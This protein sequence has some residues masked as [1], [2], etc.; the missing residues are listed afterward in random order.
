[1]LIHPLLRCMRPRKQRAKPGGMVM[2]TEPDGSKDASVDTKGRYMTGKERRDAIVKALHDAGAPVSGRALAQ[3]VGVSRQ[4]VVQDM[5]LL[6]ADGHDIVAT[7]RGY[8]LRES[9]RPSVPTRL[10]KVRHTVEE[11]GDELNT[12]VD[13]GGAALN[14][15]V[16]HRVYG[17]ITADLDVRSRR[18]VERYLEGI[19]SGKSF[20]LM[21]VTSGYHFHRIAAESE[22]ILEEIEEALAAKGY[23]AEV[24]PYERDVVQA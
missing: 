15:M 19:R 11:V 24:L 10:I 3:A 23:L 21:T 22:E 16:N 2:L 7:S 13:L 18:D 12:I 6:R 5:A 9:D 17:A 8:A 1:M 20:P 14:V 4:V